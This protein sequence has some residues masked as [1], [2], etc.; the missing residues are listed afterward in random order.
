[1]PDEHSGSPN[2]AKRD[3]TPARRPAGSRHW[4]LVIVAALAIGL[5]WASRGGDKSDAPQ[6]SQAPGS[7]PAAKAPTKAETMPPWKRPE[8][9][10]VVGSLPEA[11]APQVPSQLVSFR[12]RQPQ[13]DDPTTDGWD[14]EL[15][16]NRLGKQL[17]LLGKMIE[18]PETIDREHAA[19]MVA[20]DF[21]C[22]ALHP[23]SLQEVLNDGGLIVLRSASEK[24]GVQGEAYRD[25]DG[26]V[27]ALRGLA[28][29]FEDATD[30]H[31]KAKIV[32]VDLRDDEVQVKVLFAASAH[33]PGG[34]LERNSTWNCGYTIDAKDPRLRF[35]DLQAYEEVSSASG[36]LF[37]DCTES[38]LGGN[39]SYAKQIVPGIPH[40]LKRI[41]VSLEPDFEGMQGLALGDVNGDDLDDL[42]VCQG[43]GVP[44]QLFI[45]QLDGTA[46]DVSARSGVDLIETTRGALFVD[47]DNDADQ[48]LVVTTDAQLLVYENDGTGRFSERARDSDIALGFSLAAAD[49]DS[50]GDLDVYVCRYFTESNKNIG[51]LPNPVPYHDANNGGRNALLR[52]DGGWRFVNA[53][54][55]V[56]LDV[57]NE[58]WSYAAGWED[59]DNDGDM[60]LY[61]ANDFG[62]NSL[63]R[64]DGGRFTDVASRAGVEDV[65]SGMSVSWGDYNR[66]GLMD[67]YVGNMFSSA[68]G[69]IAF[70]ERFQE[71]ASQETKAY[72]QRLARGNSLFQNLGDGTFSDVT[73]DAG[74]TMGRWSWS[75]NFAD[76]NNDGWEDLVIANGYITG[77][78]T[79]D[80]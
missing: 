69:R 46:L 45:Q 77:E 13:I 54:N 78:D 5:F 79:G 65:A 22:D 18:H 44:N 55:A 56:G 40:W 38:V 26:L 8:L 6:T 21:R 32:R 74:V 50:D 72:Y 76:I 15:W 73:D 34:Y 47:L 4:L 19:E 30:I 24:P 36:A 70:Q 75:S 43:G 39:D 27:D 1:M 25:A 62:R 66:D 48:D 64:N 14:T 7:V 2:P 31:T 58:R 59:Y 60:D 57:N 61:V 42:Y 49:Y 68:G 23:E 29:G 9:T 37:S 28:A 12:V 17:K 80:L 52:N 33:A 3:Q 53:T 16:N 63:Y 71:S 67:L 20:S 41:D 10:Q 11:S 35:I 51:Q